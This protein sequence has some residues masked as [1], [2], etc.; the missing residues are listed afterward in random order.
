MFVAF[1]LVAA[2]VLRQMPTRAAFLVVANLLNLGFVLLFFG[3]FALTIL[4][5]IMLFGLALLRLGERYGTRVIPPG[6]AL[7]AIIF[8]VIKQYPFIP[9]VDLL[10]QIGAVVGVSYIVFRLVHLVIYASEK[11]IARVGEL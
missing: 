5:G 6:I 2:L 11:S 4:M 10:T 1:G 8:V 7:I 3:P 9:K